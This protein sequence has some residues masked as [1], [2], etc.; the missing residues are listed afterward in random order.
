[1]DCPAGTAS[2]FGTADAQNPQ[3]CR[4]EVEHL[5]DALANHM[6]R[7]TAAGTNALIDIERYVFAG[8]ML[9]ESIL[10]WR[11]LRTAVVRRCRWMACLQ[12]GNIGVVVFQSESKLVSIDLFRPP[13]ELH[14]L[15]PPNDELE[16]LDLSQRLGK[17]GSVAGIL[18]SQVTHQ[19]VQRIS[20]ARQRGEVD[21]HAHHLT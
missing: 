14:A 13:S 9:G 20:I 16:S 11:G 19:S 3:P 7:T 17:L 2:I 6:E 15:E 8:Q 18:R 4:H 12:A 1:M 21:V 5:T 10:A